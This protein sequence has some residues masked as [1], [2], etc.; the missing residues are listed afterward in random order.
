MVSHLP[1]A[2]CYSTI[3][4][5]AGDTHRTFDKQASYENHIMEMMLFEDG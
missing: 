1:T 5:L 3:S 4:G 2:I